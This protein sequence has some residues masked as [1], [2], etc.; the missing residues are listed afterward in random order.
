MASSDKVDVVII[1]AGICGSMMA[2]K[3]ASGGKKV[4]IL[5]QGPAWRQA[6]M[7]SSGIWSRRLKWSG[8]AVQAGG[9]NPLGH[10]GNAGW[11]NGGAGIHHYAQ[12]PRLHPEDFRTKTLYGR[13]VDWPFTYEDLR[14]AYDRVQEEVG[15]SGDHT[16]EPW[17]P[18]G[19]PYPMP[20][21]KVFRHAEIIAEGFA[22]MGIPTAPMPLGINSVDYKG[23]PACIYDGWCDAG[24]PIG[25]LV[26]PLATYLPV[27]IKAGT[28]IRNFSW[29]TRI[30]T[31]AAGKRATGVEYFDAKKER[32][33]QMADV[34]VVA[35]NAQQNAR[36]LLIS[37]DSAHPNGLANGSGA[38]GKYFMGHLSV[39]YNG[40]F[41]EAMEPWFGVT[42]ASL[43]SQAD[44]KKDAHGA[45]FGSYT[46][47][48]GNA[49][50]PGNAAGL[51]PNMF[52][53]EL[54]R[55]MKDAVRHVTGFGSIAEQLPR[56]E[57]AIM[58]SDLKDQFGY[59]LIKTVHAADDTDKAMFAYLRD[60][61]LEI[62]K[63]AGAKQ[64]WGGNA[65]GWQHFLGGTRMGTNPADS[66]CDGHAMAH[67]LPNL[68]LTGTG[69]FP[70]EG[71]SHPTF[72]SH[73]LTLRT[74]DHI[75]ANWSSIAA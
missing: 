12:W 28:E 1:G 25:S 72:T 65:F 10:A 55:F 23:R 2:A 14:P 64:I 60:K 51:N 70:T 42:G 17:R 62:I 3:L 66:V 15:I 21:I 33:V 29:V 44:Y 69:I 54:H 43:Y 46:W 38:V 9:A 26:D 47:T 74:A 68:A 36:L 56:A 11:G 27:A 73:A 8:P 32:H 19:D 50:K 61:G 35:G 58:L 5:E 13:A 71:G 40:W 20:P 4:V 6:D 75:L 41:D 53:D 67:E 39:G 18:A 37:A 31:D 22:K 24:C 52:G 30:V 34:V 63:A 59:P 49:R 48:L 45:A 57:N 7:I 16:K